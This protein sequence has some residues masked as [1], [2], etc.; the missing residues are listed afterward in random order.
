MDSN[1]PV[2]QFIIVDL[3]DRDLIWNSKSKKHKDRNAVHDAWV[4]FSRMYKIDIPLND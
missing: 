4:E 3:E 2:L 1:E